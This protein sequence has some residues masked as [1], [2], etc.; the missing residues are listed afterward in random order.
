[1]WFGQRPPSLEGLARVEDSRLVFEMNAETGEALRALARLRGQSPEALAS[2]LLL[3]GLEGEARRAQVEA[4]LAALTPRERQVAWRSARGQTNR[5]I[6]QAL[7]I[8]PETV[9]THVA[10]VLDK[11][12][13]ASKAD[14]RILLLDLGVRGWEGAE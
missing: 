14:L 10:H 2:A 9:K 11:L 8:S 12:E 13:V 4:V 3:R 7:V 6:A 1:M 5:Q